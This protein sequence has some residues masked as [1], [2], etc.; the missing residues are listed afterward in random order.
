[1]AESSLHEDAL[2]RPLAIG[3]KGP[4]Q[5]PEPA[6][7]PADVND[8]GNEDE[9][10]DVAESDEPEDDTDEACDESYVIPFSYSLTE[11][12]MRIHAD[13]GDLSVIVGPWGAH[14]PG[15]TGH[16]E[17]NGKS[18]WQ[19]LYIDTI[20]DARLLRIEPDDS[21]VPGGCDWDWNTQCVVARSLVEERIAYYVAPSDG[22]EVTDV[23]IDRF[24]AALT[25]GRAGGCRRHPAG[26]VGH[27]GAGD[28]RRN[29]LLR[30]RRRLLLRTAAARL[31]VT[32]RGHGPAQAPAPGAR[33][34]RAAAGSPLAWERVLGAAVVG[35]GGAVAGRRGIDRSRHPGIGRG[36]ARGQQK[37]EE[38]GS[39]TAR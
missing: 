11:A 4:E 16:A 14:T 5:V 13:G 9:D 12:G 36:G 33:S 10:S 26:A 2:G 28:P 22:F 1:M 3:C 18:D 7:D 21:L 29:D 24:D 15:H 6:G 17:G 37:D 19:G 38:G 30:R 35:H 8:D 31:P 20:D 27:P 39:Y 25:V 34:I 32:P 23:H